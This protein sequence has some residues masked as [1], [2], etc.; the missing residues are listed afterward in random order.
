MI[1]TFGLAVLAP[2]GAFAQDGDHPQPTWAVDVGVAG[3]NIVAGALTAAVTAVIRGEDV[4]EAFLKGAVGGAVVFAGKRVTVERFDGAGL[5]GRQI[6]SVGTGMVVDGGRGRAWLSEV[7]VPIGP[8]SVQVGSQERWRWRVNL[9]DVGILVWAATRSELHFDFG[10]SVS[11]GAPV[12]VAR[13]HR[14]K[15]DSDL[16]AGT[17]PGGVILLGVTSGADPEATQR[18]ENVHIIQNDYL[19]GTLSRPTEEWAW[20]RFAGWTVPVDLHLLRHLSF[21]LFRNVVEH[22]ADALEVR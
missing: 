4:S 15:R 6:A 8:A 2:A 5:L 10:R 19:L 13:N 16:K 1:F 14:L 11:N 3:A 20:Q 21:Y 22:E 18:H 12:F 9:Q 17:A 7:W